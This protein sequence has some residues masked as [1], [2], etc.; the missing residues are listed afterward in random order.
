VPRDGTGIFDADIGGDRL[1]P[2]PTLAA[3][4]THYDEPHD[5][6]FVNSIGGGTTGIT[7]DATGHMIIDWNVMVTS[8]FIH[9]LGHRLGLLHPGHGPQHIM[10]EFTSP[11]NNELKSD[12]VDNYE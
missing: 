7:S 8:T 6:T 5:L 4:Q 2:A 11:I 12:E 1:D 3:R 9:E 10:Y